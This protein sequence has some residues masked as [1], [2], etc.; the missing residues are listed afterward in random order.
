MKDYASFHLA[1]PVLS[2]KKHYLP[3][4]FFTFIN[5]KGYV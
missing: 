3:I 1:F 4:L 2:Y 5:G